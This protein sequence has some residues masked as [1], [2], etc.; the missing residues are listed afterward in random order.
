MTRFSASAFDIACPY[1]HPSLIAHP[2][3]SL[4]DTKPQITANGIF[5]LSHQTLLTSALCKSQT[6]GHRIS[7][8]SKG[9]PYGSVSFKSMIGLVCILV[10]EISQISRHNYGLSS[11]VNGFLISAITYGIN[12]RG[13]F[14]RGQST[15][16]FSP[17]MY[18]L[19]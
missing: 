17:S 6:F 11:D 18:A 8:T 13:G 3:D 12:V 10:G 14:T 19:S 4:A 9:L 7:T 5:I 2:T 16:T 15:G 1:Q